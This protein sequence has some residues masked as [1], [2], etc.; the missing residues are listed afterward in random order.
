MASYPAC[1]QNQTQTAAQTAL[2]SEPRERAT[3]TGCA[4]GI[5]FVIPCNPGRLAEP[6]GR[7]V[8]RPMDSFPWRRGVYNGPTQP[9]EEAGRWQNSTARKDRDRRRQWYRRGIAL[10]ALAAEGVS[11]VICGRRASSLV[12]VVEAI[13]TPPADGPSGGRPPTSPGTTSP[14]WWPRRSTPGTVHILV[15]NA[16]VDAPDA[17]I[18]EYSIEE[19]D[20]VMPSSY[21]GPF[22][23]ARAVLPLCGGNALRATSSTSSSEAGLELLRKAGLHG[24]QIRPYLNAWAN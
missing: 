18:H 9:I 14:A 11:V 1:E 22:L 17:P 3:W 13:L 21:A 19:W 4:T 7:A 16:G 10:L 8:A 12:R 5:S 15:N 20:R 23:M 2:R 24:Q 6:P